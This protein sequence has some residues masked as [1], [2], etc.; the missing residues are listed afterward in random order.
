MNVPTSSYQLLPQTEKIEASTTITLP[1]YLLTSPELREIC[2]RLRVDRSGSRIACLIR[3]D[4]KMVELREIGVVLRDVKFAQREIV[5]RHFHYVKKIW[6]RISFTE[7]S[8]HEELCESMKDESWQSLWDPEDRSELLLKILLACP[9]ITDLDIDIDIPMDPTT[10]IKPHPELQEALG[11]LSQFELP[12]L[13][14]LK[15]SQH[16]SINFIRAFYTS[17]NLTKLSLDK[18]TYVKYDDLVKLIEDQIWSNL[19]EFEITHR[20]TSRDLPSGQIKELK[21]MCQRNG[22][23]MNDTHCYEEYEH[24]EP[25]EEDSMDESEEEYGGLYWEM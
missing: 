1:T 14:S 10:D 20:T 12:R 18:V 21:L 6:W 19:Q 17:R 11:G 8:V 9:R 7:L 5:P 24:P 23:Q 2:R 22:I 3:I 16:L 4:A 15:T 25:Q 13:I